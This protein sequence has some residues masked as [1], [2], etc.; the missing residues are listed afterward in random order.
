MTRIIIQVHVLLYPLYPNLAV[1]IYLF[2]VI[3][4]VFKFTESEELFYPLSLNVAITL[5]L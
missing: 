3:C 2:I 5:S 4:Y 1:I